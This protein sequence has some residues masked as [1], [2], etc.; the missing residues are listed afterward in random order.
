VVSLI[1]DGPGATRFAN[2]ALLALGVATA[3]GFVESLRGDRAKPATRRRSSAHSSGSRT[4]ALAVGAISAFASQM[5]F[6]PGM[7]IAAGDVP[8]PN[9]VA[10]LSRL[11]LPWTWS[12]SDLGSPSALEQQLPW[13]F[14]VWVINVA[15]GSA[16]LAERLWFAGFFTVATIA[17]LALL[18]TL[19]IGPIGSVIGALA[20]AFSPFVV[21]NLIPNPVVL[22]AF[23]LLPALPT[24]VVLAA[25]GRINARTAVTFLAISG[26]LLGWTYVNPPT[27]GIVL[28]AVLITPLIAWWIYGPTGARRSLRVLAFGIPITILFSLYWI[29]PSVLQLQ[30]AAFAQLAAVTDWSWTES[31]ATIRNGFWLNTSWAW[32]YREYFPFAPAYE[33]YP[34][35]ILKFAPAIVAFGSL[36]LRHERSPS[37]L[38][39]LRMSTAAAALALALI[40]LGTGTN[41]PGDVVFNRLY[42]LP[43]GWLLREPGRFLIVADLAFAI[44][45]AITVQRLVQFD[46]L[47]SRVDTPNRFITSAITV[48]P[49][50]VL[51]LTPGMPLLTGAIVPDNRAPLPSM[52]V[53]MPNY[54]MEMASYINQ[55]PGPGGIL[56]LPPDDFYQM[57]YKWGYYGSDGFIG[58]LVSRPILIP[59]QQAYFPTSAQLL[60]VEELAA[61]SIT[62]YDWQLEGNLLGVLGTPWV[63]VRDDLD[64]TF[65]GRTF[66]SPASLV[67]ALQQA[68]NF[69]LVHR[70]GPLWLFRL[71]GAHADE[72]FVAPHFATVNTLTPDLRV[73]SRL[74]DQTALVSRSPLA[75]VPTV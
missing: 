17:C 4:S 49:L 68:G 50:V 42:A 67:G 71:R 47:L 41:P 32:A 52:H 72:P 73:L 14:V 69:N 9:G 23:A 34:L 51:V 48:I 19:G 12:G 55:M 37:G 27:L 2:V 8:P 40:F 10:W 25:K 13:A 60:S 24:I 63:L 70:S 35:S 66:Q 62:S 31:R 28:A 30:Q 36:A 57:P 75:G 56:V 39:L 20:Y 46:V 22:V 43:L 74:P 6:R 33:V 5:W 11:F 21:A 3:L 26:P 53:R 59:G 65:A 61:N 64:T 58:Q 38:N 18:R 15:G 44:L 16:E 7:A 1:A 54:W 45:V 29:V